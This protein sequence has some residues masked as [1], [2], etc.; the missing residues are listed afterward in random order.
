MVGAVYS[1]KTIVL[2]L[3]KIKKMISILRYNKMMFQV[4]NR[5]IVAQ[6]QIQNHILGMGVRVNFSMEIMGCEP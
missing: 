2:P 3:L 1:N 5:K 4:L 6:S